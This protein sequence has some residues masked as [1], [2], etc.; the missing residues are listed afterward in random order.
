MT[1]AD[2]PLADR[3]ADLRLNLPVGDWSV[4]GERRPNVLV[5]GPGDAAHAFVDAVTPY[6]QAPVHHLTC[7]ARL[8]LPRG[9]GTLILEHLDALDREQQEC[10]LRWLDDPEH[11]RTQVISLTPAP[12]YTSVQRETFLGALYYRLNVI[13]LEVGS[14]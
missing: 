6:L 1:L 11:A 9:D 3:G 14:S 12:L 7:D 13:Y 5:S 10:L 2:D 8:D 4:L